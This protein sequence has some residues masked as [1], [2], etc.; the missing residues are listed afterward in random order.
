MS[1]TTRK[2]L[3]QLRGK[4][5]PPKA[6]IYIKK[7]RRRH[8]DGNSYHC[9]SMV[10]WYVDGRWLFPR[11]VWEGARYFPTTWEADEPLTFGIYHGA[12]PEVGETHAYLWGTSLQ[13]RKSERYMMFEREASASRFIDIFDQAM[14]QW[15]KLPF[16]EKI[17]RSP[18]AE[19]IEEETLP[20][21]PYDT[22]EALFDDGFIK[23]VYR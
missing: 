5:A 2:Q 18:A 19:F 6:V 11:V 8:S 13:A 3:R 20:Q 12:V 10:V 4:T 16:W 17:Q 1:R 15:A 9:V 21:A 14:Q 7:H 23:R 22:E